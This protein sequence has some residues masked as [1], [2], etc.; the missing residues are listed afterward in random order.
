MKKG[1]QLLILLLFITV[2]SQSGKKFPIIPISKTY[3]LGFKTYDKE[4][5]MYK[6][7]FILKGGK[8]YNIQGYDNENYSGGQILSISPNKKYIV[9]DYISK[10]YLGDGTCKILI[11]S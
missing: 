8:K 7:P 3:Q 6:K 10:G 5:K 4:F 2:F 11:E 1:I 9:L